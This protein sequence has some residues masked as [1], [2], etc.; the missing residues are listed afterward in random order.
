LVNDALLAI[1]SACGLDGAGT[2]DDEEASSVQALVD[3]FLAHSW[4]YRDRTSPLADEFYGDAEE[5]L[6][7]LEDDWNISWVL[8]ERAEL[9]LEQGKVDGTLEREWRDAADIVQPASVEAL[10]GSPPDEELTANLH[11]VRGDVCWNAGQHLRA[12]SWYRR[13]VLHAYLFHGTSAP[14]NKPVRPDEYTLQFYV[15]IRARALS[16][17]LKLVEAG[18]IDTA[19]LCAVEL[20]R[21]QEDT[22]AIVPDADTVKQQLMDAVQGTG[23]QDLADTLFPPGPHVT[24]LRGSATSDLA[25]ES[26][27]TKDFRARRDRVRRL[28]ARR[29]RDPD[30]VTTSRDL[31]DTHWP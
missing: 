13:S 18:D 29:A 25:H 23:R 21:V 31:H 22:S 7:D 6:R 10:G 28:D 12:A 5:R 9:R 30:L 4:R 14:Q 26:A 20:A 2:S 27:F 16:K 17:L 11:R 3:I 24:D 8:A 15:D 1:G 19:L